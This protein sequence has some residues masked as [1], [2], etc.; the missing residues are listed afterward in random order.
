MIQRIQSVYLLLAAAVTLAVLVT[1]G[2][3]T[4]D[5][6]AWYTPVKVAASILVAVGCLVAIFL[7]KD[8]SRQRMLVTIVLWLSL[9]LAVVLAGASALA[10]GLQPSTAGPALLPVLALVL[11]ILARRGISKDIELVRSMDRLR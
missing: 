10:D 6:W 2:P 5:G 1:P 7:Y 8:R 11:I 9:A 3:I 4:P